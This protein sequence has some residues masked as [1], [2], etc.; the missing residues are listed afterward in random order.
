MNNSVL[1]S[2]VE[3]EVTT[4]LES[5]RGFR[6]VVFKNLGSS[7]DRIQ[8]A[9]DKLPFMGAGS[10][11]SV[12]GI[13]SGKVIKMVG[14]KDD[15]K[16]YLKSPTS[17]W[18]K[19]FW[20]TGVERGYLQ[21]RAEIDLFTHPQARPI[22]AEIFDFADDYSWLICEAAQTLKNTRE[23][24]KFLGFP[25]GWL[26]E[27]L[28]IYNKGMTDSALI[29]L[30]NMMGISGVKSRSKTMLSRLGEQI[31]HTFETRDE[32]I[33]Y[34]KEDLPNQPHFSAIIHLVRNLGHSTQDLNNPDHWGKTTDGRIVLLDYGFT[35]DVRSKY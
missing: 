9:S 1:Q 11:R 13:G 33:L 24:S 14:N 35:E 8:Y 23:L 29:Q 22:L 15:L 20:L 26:T 27:L 5:F 34:L 10:A 2:L 31:G 16:D 6:L 28:E 32:F 12:F 7:Q 18:E 17:K 19:K 25:S 21:N 3:Q 4:I 30:A